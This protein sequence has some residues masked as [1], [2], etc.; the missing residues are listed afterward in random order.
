MQDISVIV[1][2]QRAFFEKGTTK[3]YGFRIQALLRLE[4]A[5]FEW[6]E[7]LKEALWQDL[8]KSASECYM[9][10]LGMVKSELI[11]V[12]KHLKS[13]MRQTPVKTALSQFPAH[14]F[15]V[16]EPY[17]IVLIMA[18]W[19][20]P[21]LLCLEPLLEA[22]AA[23]NCV[24]LKPSAYAP[25]VSAVLKAMLESVFPQKLV[26]VIEGGREVNQELLKQRFDYIFF[27]GSAAV[28]RTV[29]QEAAKN[30]TPVTLELGGKS[31]CIVDETADITK[32]AK[33]II[34]GKILNAGQTCVAPDYV[35]VQ[36]SVKDRF[37]K[38]LEVEIRRA[39][40]R[41]PLENPD[42]PKIINEKH[43]R[44]LKGLLKGT[45]IVAGGGMDEKQGRIAPTVLDNVT[46]ESPVMQEEI[47]GPLLPIMTYSN[48]YELKGI[49]G[50]FEK[51]L[52]LYLFTGNRYMQDWV[53]ENFSFGG[54]CI[55]DTI[56]QLASPYLPFG[57]VGGSGMGSYHG[58]RGFETFSHR[59]SIMEQLRWPDVPLRYQP[60]E[61]W[62]DRVIRKML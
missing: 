30:L 58:K 21:V 41:E 35:L 49:I 45:E 26:A 43:F 15:T 17:G 54:G 34:F 4:S 1:K 53:L 3:K 32:A 6:E 29:M 23:G 55:N 20:Y 7:E 51:P 39:L 13:W 50:H 59:K 44:R 24:I 31:P 47:F 10:E 14:A 2:Q 8:H 22:L 42:Y 56:L 28:G 57:G 38:A 9:T 37:I 11:Y 18:P 48:I 40:G 60:Y 62:K 27:T 5:L 36:K 52:A 19:N 61:G 12:R 16:P 46:L 25:H 33:R